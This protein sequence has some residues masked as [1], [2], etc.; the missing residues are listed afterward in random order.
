MGKLENARRLCSPVFWIWLRTS[1]SRKA[2]RLMSNRSTCAGCSVRPARFW[3]ELTMSLRIALGSSPSASATNTGSG[4]GIRPV[5]GGAVRGFITTSVHPPVPSGV[6]PARVV[7]QFGR[8]A[9]VVPSAPVHCWTLLFASRMTF[10]AVTGAFGDHVGLTATFYTL[11]LG[12]PLKR[13]H[14]SQLSPFKDAGYTPLIPIHR[15]LPG[16]V[17]VTRFGSPEL[18]FNCHTIVICRR[19]LRLAEASLPT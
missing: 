3:N 14:T 13:F 6:K 9:P 2:Y 1:Y 8:A 11:S 5:S 15:N 19:A 7:D 16:I 18:S 17:I 4:N 12:K 10:C